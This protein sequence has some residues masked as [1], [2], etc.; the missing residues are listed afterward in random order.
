MMKVKPSFYGAGRPIVTAALLATWLWGAGSCGTAA[1]QPGV[2]AG[3]APLDPEIA[4]LVAKLPASDAATVQQVMSDLIKMGPVGIVKLIAA[5]V[6]PDAVD[7]PKAGDAKDSNGAAA[8]DGRV[9]LALYGLAT[10]VRRP[11]AEA[12]RIMY[13]GTLAGELA[14]NRP[15]PVKAFLIQQLHLAG[16][17]EVVPQL[18]R[19]LSDNDLSDDAAQALVAL[20]GEARDPVVTALRAA[21]ATTQGRQRAAV[22]SS[23]GQLRDSQTVPAL[24]AAANDA[25]PHVRTAVLGALAN[26]GDARAVDT[27]LKAAETETLFDRDTASGAL[28]IL[29]RRLMEAGAKNADI[30]RLYRQLYT[31]R[32]APEDR[33]VRL[34]ALRGLALLPGVQ[35]DQ[36]LLAALGADDRVLREAAIAAVAAMPSADTANRW[37][38][39]LGP[40]SARVRAAILTALGRRGDGAALP[41]ILAAMQDTDSDVRRAAVAAAGNF[42][43]AESV[44]ALTALLDRGDGATS[45]AA[46]QALMGLPGAA[47]TT[48][49]AGAL[50]MASGATRAT[51]LHALAVRGATGGTAQL[52]AIRPYL[53]DKD[54][55]VRGAALAAYGSL[56]DEKGLP[57]LIGLLTKAQTDADRAAVEKALAA[58]TRGISDTGGRVEPLIAALAGADV[59]VRSALLSVL[60]Q[61]GGSRA[62]APL[63][64]ALQ[65]PNAEIR[66]IAVR[67]LSKWTNPE[68]VPTLLGLAKSAPNQ[69]HR[70]LALQG[71]LRLIGDQEMAPAEKLRVYREALELAQRPED[72]RLVLAG[73]GNIGSLE[74]LQT[75]APFLTD[76]AIREEAAAAVVSIARR[77]TGASAGQ[78]RLHLQQVREVS[79]NEPVRKQAQ[80]LL[81]TL[82]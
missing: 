28:F 31:T 21:L 8:G 54:A 66:D 14:G 18:G 2:P 26:I 43:T 61:A 47:A 57:T 38:G 44:Q 1:A 27:L 17:A 22:I 42:G 34:A 77:L 62:Y 39:H 58:A 12:E 48:A 9:E 73:V 16:G 49:M 24:L 82:K 55:N 81:D 71:Y 35:I 46:Q 7:G 68:A 53:E 19:L 60:G 32:T 51:L 79:K 3:A 52:D 72:K 40:A 76:D 69:T 78:V 23:L 45:Q 36:E 30:E 5:L 41:A 6:E 11:G 63:Q 10:H 70:V 4:A 25:N 80:E 29:A 56:T 15:A 75:V 20:Q 64:A 33:H 13:A 37:A 65:D 50:A 74:A 67:S 59:P